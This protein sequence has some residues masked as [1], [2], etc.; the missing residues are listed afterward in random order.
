M[1]VEP[2]SP[3]AN[4]QGWEEV[5]HAQ[6][7]KQETDQRHGEVL[8]PAPQAVICLGDGPRHYPEG[9]QH[10]ELDVP[11]DQGEGEQPQDG[12][13]HLEGEVD[14]AVGQQTAQ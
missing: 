1:K 5:L 14:V 2:A 8:D 6:G 11:C 7:G 3:R 13:Q 12:Q 10:G 4:S 9:E